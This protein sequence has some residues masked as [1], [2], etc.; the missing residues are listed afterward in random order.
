MK[1]LKSAGCMK[2]F[3][4]LTNAINLLFAIRTANTKFLTFEQ[5]VWIAL[6]IDSRMAGFNGNIRT[7][8]VKN[9]NELFETEKRAKYSKLLCN[10][11]NKMEFVYILLLHSLP[12]PSL[13]KR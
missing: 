8:C 10:T 9:T 4:I 6:I 7:E 1:Y 12:L 3:F 13:D 5:F 2:Y 11:Y